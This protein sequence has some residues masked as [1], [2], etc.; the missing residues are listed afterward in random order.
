MATE[1]KAVNATNQKAR[2]EVLEWPPTYI[3]DA[4]AAAKL[5]GRRLAT[6]AETMR[7]IKTLVTTRD[8]WHLL[9]VDPKGMPEKPGWYRVVHGDEISFASVPWDEIQALRGAER[10]DEVLC[11]CEDAIGAVKEGLPLALD[12]NSGTHM[13]SLFVYYRP[14]FVARMPLVDLDQKPEAQIESLLR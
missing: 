1:E 3:K 13:R 4:Y 2:I 6:I 7:D 12:I 9:A 5:V 14:F 8:K 11:V 10:W